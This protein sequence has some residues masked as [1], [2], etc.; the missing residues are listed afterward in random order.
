MSNLFQR[1]ELQ[2][3]RAGVTP[4][5]KESRDW[6][7]QKASN[8]RSINR[9]ALMREDPLKK[10]D[11][12]KADNRELIGSMQMFFYDPK[13]KKTLPYYDLF[14]LVIIVGPAKDGFYG[15]NLHYL[16]PILRAKFLDALMDVIGTK[17]TKSSRMRLTYGIL[18]KTA[19]MRYYKPCLKHYLTKHVKSRFAEVQTPE[20]EIATF[21]PTAQF[22]KANSQK[23]FYDSRQ[24]IDG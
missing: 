16:P 14:P 11:A 2:A 13:H 15:L 23:V 7:R 18:Q 22:R 21:L 17:M 20:W 1:L 24:K 6:F 9:E 4:R 12:S 19:K 5:T 10:R 8:L 3:F